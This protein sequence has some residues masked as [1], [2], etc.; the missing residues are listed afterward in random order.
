MGDGVLVEFGSD[1]PVMFGNRRQENVR[2]ARLQAAS[3]PR[4]VGPRHAAV[5]D[6][7]SREKGGE[8]AS[9]PLS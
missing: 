3:A 8:A 1:A 7:V 5:A 9:W 6:Y 2:P 4:L